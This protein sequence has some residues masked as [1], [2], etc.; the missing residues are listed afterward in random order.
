MNLKII[1]YPLLHYIR[2]HS[3][4]EVSE[5]KLPKTQT[6]N[7]TTSSAIK[8]EKYSLSGLITYIVKQGLKRRIITYL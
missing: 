7:T 6:K 5:I 1:G 2:F 3:Y 8:L 4:S